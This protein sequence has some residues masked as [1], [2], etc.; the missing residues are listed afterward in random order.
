M[1]R[2]GGLC[3]AGPG[4]TNINKVSPRI[5]ALQDR[6]M[7]SLPSDGA[8]ECLSPAQREAII[9]LHRSRLASTDDS[10][11]HGENA[12]GG[13]GAEGLLE[14]PGL[15]RRCRS[16]SYD[17][18]LES[19]T[20]DSGVRGV[21]GTNSSG[22]ASHEDSSSDQGVKR[23]G[24]IG[25][26]FAKAA[27]ADRATKR[28]VKN[29]MHELN[30]MKNVRKSEVVTNGFGNVNK[31]ISK[32]MNKCG[33][34]P[35]GTSNITLDCRNV[36]GEK[37]R[38]SRIDVDGVFRD[39]SLE[40]NL[41]AIRESNT[42]KRTSAASDSQ[43]NR[44]GISRRNILADNY[45]S[46]N[47]L[48][49]L[50]EVKETV[51]SEEYDS[52]VN[53]KNDDSVDEYIRNRQKGGCDLNHH[54]FESDRTPRSDSTSP[55][56]P[57]KRDRSNDK[58]PK[59]DDLTTRKPSS[60][61]DPFGGWDHAGEKM[62]KTRS[63][64]REGRAVMSHS[65][66][67]HY[68]ERAK[69]KSGGEPLKRS[70]LKVGYGAKLNSTFDYRT[71]LNQDQMNK[72]SSNWNNMILSCDVPIKPS[73]A[74]SSGR[75]SRFTKNASSGAM[76][77]STGNLANKSAMAAQK[78][79]DPANWGMSDPRRTPNASQDR[80]AG[81]KYV[82]SKSLDRKYL[83]EDTSDED[84]DFET[85]RRT[86]RTRRYN[87]G[88][89][90]WEV[91]DGG[92]GGRLR[93][94]DR[95][96]YRSREMLDYKYNYNGQNVRPKAK[97]AW[98]LSGQSKRVEDDFDEFEDVGFRT[99]SDFRNRWQSE[100]SDVTRR[101]KVSDSS[102]EFSR[103]Q[104]NRRSCDFELDY[105]SEERE[106]KLSEKSVEFDRKRWY[107]RSCDIDQ[108]FE[109]HNRQRREVEF[110]VDWG[111][112]ALEQYD[113]FE[114]EP[115]VSPKSNK[116]NRIRIAEQQQQLMQAHDVERVSKVRY[117]DPLIT[118]MRR[119]EDENCRKM[120]M[121]DENCRKMRMDDENCRKMRLE[122]ENGRQTRMDDFGDRRMRLDDVPPGRIPQQSQQ[123]L[124]DEAGRRTRLEEHYRSKTSMG[125]HGREKRERSKTPHLLR[126]K[127]RLLKSILSF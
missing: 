123:R 27:S 114:P 64:E 17:D 89:Q 49:S 41:E 126:G 108:D 15:P 21:N 20:D 23:G 1:F 116:K 75:E 70:N 91:G 90:D 95:I 69:T 36:Q 29:E 38:R 78:K 104:W 37:R 59:G 45:V 53:F 52:G 103:M 4:D 125:Y 76:T 55:T 109:Y 122:N 9:A 96:R 119:M 80:S 61:K 8:W 3:L 30:N 50:K 25:G 82:R 24:G 66:D 28:D 31:I 56:L 102:G 67:K 74:P 44:V 40:R 71:N 127:L 124:D 111:R 58:R 26:R 120:R 113:D 47:K 118:D 39:C 85:R 34:V 79:G 65:L 115:V 57:L 112:R 68:Q 117:G 77:R 73:Q 121:D 83:D 107:R 88:S 93:P 62:E 60:E 11:E 101:K 106:R 87:R 6:L 97:S 14:G 42:S 100:D 63:R 10:S 33:A 92:G 48:H 13:G 19:E 54:D 2:G 94:D 18:R 110:D 86:E 35:N 81:K 99:R 43:Q 22:A 84:S 105:P 16:R 12:R 32:Q 46:E 98:D 7:D 5:R 51:S 72:Y